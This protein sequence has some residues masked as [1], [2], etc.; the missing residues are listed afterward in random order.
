MRKML[1]LGFVIIGC[2]SAQAEDRLKFPF[3]QNP[4]IK[5]LRYN[6]DG[7]TFSMKQ[8]SGQWRIE[9]EKRNSSKIIKSEN[10]T[11][12]KADEILRA[13][14]SLY[15]YWHDHLETNTDAKSYSMCV[16]I[17]ETD[18]PWVTQIR[19]RDAGSAQLQKLKEF[20][21]FADLE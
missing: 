21:D 13:L 5:F 3:S 18:W 7:A 14:A 1:F 8:V 17:T 19:V 12:E 15:F 6:S 16:W 9:L 20:I 10:I 2:L 11:D 4:E